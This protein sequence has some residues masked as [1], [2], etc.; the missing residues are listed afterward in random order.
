MTS[1]DYFKKN[2][3]VQPETIDDALAK[4]LEAYNI[5]VNDLNQRGTFG[6]N[7]YN[8][9]SYMSG[10]QYAINNISGL[11]SKEKKKIKNISAQQE[12][13]NTTNNDFQTIRAD[14]FRLYAQ[15]STDDTLNKSIKD[16]RKEQ[17]VYRGIDLSKYAAGKQESIRN[18]LSRRDKALADISGVGGQ[19]FK[20]F[21]SSMGINKNVSELSNSEINN[22][23][24]TPQFQ[25]SKFSNLEP[26]L[27]MLGITTKNLDGVFK[28][29]SQTTEKKFNFALEKASETISMFSANATTPNISSTKLKEQLNSAQNAIL[30]L[31]S[32][33]KASIGKAEQQ[34]TEAATGLT[35][36][37]KFLMENL[38]GV[39]SAKD[40]ITTDENG[41]TGLDRLKKLSQSGIITDNQLMG[42]E[43]SA[44]NYS[45]GVENVD[46]AEY[47]G[48]QAAEKRGQLGFQAGAMGSASMPLA[49]KFT[50]IDW[51]QRKKL[52]EAGTSELQTM[53]GQYNKTNDPAEKK[54][55]KMA[56]SGTWD[57]L[58]GKLGMNSYQMK[59]AIGGG[60]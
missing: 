51:K 25:S 34:F 57:T 19:D 14:A 23:I 36:T 22:L 47:M 18:D 8:T 6:N 26:A 15:M 37:N 7:K 33:G 38:G 40:L 1:A 55:L 4:K 30:N 3:I 43:K 35:P 41:F 20:S 12:K 11:T 56:I 50:T 13:Y 44:V 39:S 60:L 16:T 29:T 42:F 2:N 31:K 9:R 48:Y 21:L 58:N 54:R 49:T 27:Q 5:N 46:K 17:T 32:T 59:A 53:V 52:R 45:Q 24:E 10:K 28:T